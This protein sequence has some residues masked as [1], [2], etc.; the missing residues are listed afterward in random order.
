MACSRLHAECTVQNEQ[1]TILCCFLCRLRSVSTCAFQTMRRGRRGA[2]GADAGASPRARPSRCGKGGHRHGGRQR[3]GSGEGE[4]RRG[5]SVTAGAAG[6]ESGTE[7]EFGATMESPCT[8][9]TRVRGVMGGSGRN[10][11]ASATAAMGRGEECVRRRQQKE[12]KGVYSAAFGLRLPIS[13]TYCGTLKIAVMLS[14]LS[15]TRPSD[16]LLFCFMSTSLASSSTRF[17]Y[18][19]KP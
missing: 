6:V 13:A 4:G 7:K 12:R 9:A 1:A 2:V 19:S 15:M 18:S 17:M 11:A 10:G 14:P 3:R 8:P 16:F 5:A